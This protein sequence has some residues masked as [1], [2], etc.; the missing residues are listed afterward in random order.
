MTGGVAG[1]SCIRVDREIEDIAALIDA[2]GGRVHL[3]GH[4]SGAALVLRAAGR[5]CGGQVRLPR[6]AVRA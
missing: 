1:T 5:A 6:P 4:S 2:V 3:Y